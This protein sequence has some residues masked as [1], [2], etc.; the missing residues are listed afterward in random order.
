[1]C[2]SSMWWTGPSHLRRRWLRRECMLGKPARDSI[3]LL[4]M[5]YCHL[6]PKMC[7]SI[8]G[9]KSSSGV[10]VWCRWSKFHCRRATCWKRMLGRCAFGRFQSEICFAGSPGPF[11]HGAGGFADSSGDFWVKAQ[12]HEDG[13]TDQVYSP[14]TSRMSSPILITGAWLTSWALTLVFLRLIVRPKFSRWRICWEASALLAR[15]V[16]PR[17]HRQQRACHAQEQFW[18][19]SWCGGELGWRVYRLWKSRV[20]GTKGERRFKRLPWLRQSPV[21]RRSS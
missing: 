9:G 20:N 21:S 6:M 8:A 18:L 5:W 19:W 13:G 12:V 14:T 10:P 17:Q 15:R 7:R 1:M 16:L 2:P 4:G 3:S 11:G